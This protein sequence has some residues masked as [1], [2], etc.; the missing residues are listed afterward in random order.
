MWLVRTYSLHLSQHKREEFFMCGDGKESYRMP[1]VMYSE[2]VIRYIT[3]VCNS[4]QSHGECEIAKSFSVL[5]RCENFK[6]REM[7]LIRDDL[8]HSVFVF[9]STPLY[10]SIAREFPEGKLHS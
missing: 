2:D 3:S 9:P 6:G 4:C 1:A 5:D 7:P 10:H 8:Q